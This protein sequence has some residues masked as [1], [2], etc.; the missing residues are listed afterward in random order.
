MNIPND[1]TRLLRDA[2][3][4]PSAAEALYHA[5]YDQLR[6]VASRQLRSERAGHTLQTT[7]LVNEAYLKL[8]D[9]NRV[10]W[11]NRAQF[12]AIASRAI[13]RILVDHARHRLR[14]KRGGGVAHEPLTEALHISSPE[15]TVDLLALDQALNQ[16]RES[17]AAKCD[18]VE[19]R[20]F[21]G[22]TN[23]EIADVLGVAER[24][25]ERHWSYARA[26]LFQRLEE[27]APRR[28]DD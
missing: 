10:D 8:I 17:D 11:Q 1:I 18:V 22:L 12:F 26:W 2:P 6:G 28:S 9:Q 16:L 5:V 24:T 14:D 19:M 15:R 7:A 20:Y 23:R 25:I 13:R 27:T 3:A 4:D 21:G